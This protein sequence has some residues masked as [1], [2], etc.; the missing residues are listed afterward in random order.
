[1]ISGE[2]ETVA[3][4]IFCPGFTLTF[5]LVLVTFLLFLVL[6]VV[7][8][9]GGVVGG[10]VVDPSQYAVSCGVKGITFKSNFPIK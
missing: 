3:L 7:A 8:A 9:D 6:L 1:M 4:V 5:E 10:A 2:F